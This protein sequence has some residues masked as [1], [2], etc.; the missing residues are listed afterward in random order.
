METVRLVSM[1]MK[2]IFSMLALSAMTVVAYG[3]IDSTMTAWD[4]FFAQEYSGDN[5]P[6]FTVKLSP[7]EKVADTIEC[8]LS[9]F[10]P[11]P[12]SEGDPVRV[13]LTC[14]ARP[15]N[16]PPTVTIDGQ[17]L[18][19]MGESSSYQIQNGVETHEYRYWY[20]YYPTGDG[21][22]T[23]RAEG[24]KFDGVE[25]NGP[26]EFSIGMPGRDGHS[27][28][29][30]LPTWMFMVITLICL[31]LEWLTFRLLF[32]REGQEELAPFVLQ[33]KRLPLD[34]SG[35]MTHYGFPSVILL[36]PLILILTDVFGAV[37]G[38]PV[39][40][41]RTVFLWC[42]AIPV[43]V[44]VLFVFIQRGKLAFWLVY[45]RL[46]TNQVHDALV[47]AADKWDWEIHYMDDDCMIATTHPSRWSLTWGEQ[48][49]VI[50]DKERIWINSVNDLNKR[51]AIAS[52]GYT[53]RNIRR[54]TEAIAAKEASS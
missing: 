11:V 24:L 47:Q 41:S 14:A 4:Q 53:K 13:A 51:T 21:V 35:A 12:G 5:K 33:H 40:W 39:G 49:F 16:V 44:A 20:K 52:F 10:Q 23:C 48:I 26:L 36:V 25:Y 32:R 1:S 2:R 37:Y 9:L 27:K 38:K 30:H 19:K 28:Q 42:V 17:A 54:V 43:A 18:D 29:N 15:D 45:T 22:F 31:V 6:H 8:T 34:P 50:F 7:A 46:D 3:E